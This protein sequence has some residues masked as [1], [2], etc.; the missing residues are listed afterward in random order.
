MNFIFDLDGT[1][2]NTLPLCIAAFRKAIEPFLGRS[3]SETE[4]TDTFGPSEEGTIRHLVPD[5][6]EAGLEAYLDWYQKLHIDYP[7][8]FEGLPEIFEDLRASGSFVGMVTGKGHKSTLITLGQYGLMQHFDAI[9]TGSPEGPVKA[10]RILEII[11]ERNDPKDSYLYVGDAPS[12]VDYCRTAGIRII[13]AA[14]ATTADLP[15]LRAKNPD[16]L[17]ESISDF[18]S[19]IRSKLN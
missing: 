8:P 11:A 13:A 10:E 9:K 12:D 1:V 14:W 6:Y 17:F 5:H 19:F 2:G 3:L 7:T 18:R 4:I 16:Y 15:R